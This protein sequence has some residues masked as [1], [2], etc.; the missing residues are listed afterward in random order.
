MAGAGKRGL[1]EIHVTDHAVLRYLERVKKV[2]LEAIRAEVRAIVA[3]APEVGSVSVTKNGMTYIVRNRVV[4]SA[5]QGK[6]H[7]L[8]LTA[9]LESVRK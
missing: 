1:A 2:D 4:V 5:I 8:P 9:R 3:L 6:H 7:V